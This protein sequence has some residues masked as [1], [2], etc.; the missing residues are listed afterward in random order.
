MAL[1][2]QELQGISITKDFLENLPQVMADE[3]QIRQ[4]AN[5]L[6]LNAGAAMPQ[7]GHLRITTSIV[8][9]K[10]IA[11]VFEDTGTGISSD[12]M[13]KIY[14]PFFSTKADG[15]GLGLSISREIIQAHQGEIKVNS[16]QGKGTTVTIRLPVG[17]M[18]RE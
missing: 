16:E 1:G 11:V 10:T 5:N 14:N 15:T 9:D 4:V 6:I 3:D 7:G 8:D 17:D 18:G 12:H 13:E 2:Y